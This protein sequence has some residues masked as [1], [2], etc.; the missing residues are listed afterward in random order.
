M[1]KTW[2][3]NKDRVERVTM[4]RVPACRF[5]NFTPS[6]PLKF[7]GNQAAANSSVVLDYSV[8]NFGVK[9]RCFPKTASPVGNVTFEAQAQE[10]CTGTAVDL[11]PAPVNATAG[12]INGTYRYV[13]TV[14]ATPGCYIMYVWMIDNQARGI[15]VQIKAAS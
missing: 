14:P 3:T 6:P 15:N 10:K 4:P 12:C 1:F 2:V 7:N 11:S 13:A 5:V 9:S 8:L